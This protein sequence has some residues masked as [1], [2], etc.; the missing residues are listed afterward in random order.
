M[1]VHEEFWKPLIE[2]TLRALKADPSH[3]NVIGVLEAATSRPTV[4]VVEA[5]NRP[6][7]GLTTYASV[8]ISGNPLPNHEDWLRTETVCVSDTSFPWI[9][10]LLSGIEEGLRN[11]AWPLAPYSVLTDIITPYNS[12][13]STKHL[14]LTPPLLW[15]ESLREF[16]FSGRKIAWL[17]LIPITDSELQFSRKHG[18]DELTRAL[19]KGDV[20][21]ANWNRTAIV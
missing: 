19:I 18:T 3:L 6:G 5:G 15:K 7:P 8:G 21:A 17:M 16:T 9:K 12:S 14:L 4:F 20:D 2:H 10:D 11:S 13:L 1:H